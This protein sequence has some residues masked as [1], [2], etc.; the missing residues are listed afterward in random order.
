MNLHFL[1]PNLGWSYIW[2]YIREKLRQVQIMESEF[3]KR[4]CLKNTVYVSVASCASDI[5]SG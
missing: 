1:L 3:V 5:N 4:D 2:T